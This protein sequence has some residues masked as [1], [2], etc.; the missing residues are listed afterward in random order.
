MQIGK[1]WDMVGQEVW[2]M[3]SREE[4]APSDIDRELSLPTGSAHRLVTY[5]WYMNNE[6]RADDAAKRKAV[7]RG[8]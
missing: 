3:F 8:R 6:D 5:R 1:L 2:A 7:Q 4:M